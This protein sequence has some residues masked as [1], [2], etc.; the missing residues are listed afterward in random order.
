MEI[1]VFV[2]YKF[3]LYYLQVLS[4][5]FGNI[6]DRYVHVEGRIRELVI[7]DIEY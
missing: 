3:A 5:G 2:S 4:G 1:N 7:I 6:A